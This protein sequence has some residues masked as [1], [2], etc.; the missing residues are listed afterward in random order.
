[1]TRIVAPS[2]TVGPFFGYALPY[3]QGPYVTAPD[4]PGA[5]I[6]HGR[7]L[8]GNSDPVPDALVEVWQADPAGDLSRRPGIYQHP[9]GFRGFGRCGTDDEGRYWF[10]TVRP[11]PVPTGDGQEQ[12]P[13]V[14]VTVFARGLLRQLVTRI[15]F[16]DEVAANA[17]D[18]LLSRVGEDRR[19]TLV[20]DPDGDGGFV[21]D[22]HLQGDKETVFLDVFDP[23]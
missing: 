13:H 14:G 17:T 4:F 21:F 11:G 16:P 23:A 9:R 7:V 12:A 22:I 10:R 1:M 5:F 6:L 2:Q 19:G 8:D 15:Y 3:A 20:A 18:P